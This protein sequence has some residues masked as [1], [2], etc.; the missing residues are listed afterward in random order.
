MTTLQHPKLKK[1]DVN[2]EGGQKFCFLGTQYHV[3]SHTPAFET[4]DKGSVKIE[5]K[6]KTKSCKDNLFLLLPNGASSD[7]K[8]LIF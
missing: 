6:E 4:A 3:L 8:K 7:I 1:S 5:K 2:L